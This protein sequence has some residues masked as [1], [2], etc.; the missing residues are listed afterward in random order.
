MSLSPGKVFQPVC[1]RAAALQLAMAVR[2]R[3]LSGRGFRRDFDQFQ[4]AQPPER[5][6]D[7]AG[8]AVKFT[9]PTVQAIGQDC[10]PMGGLSKIRQ[11]FHSH[12]KFAPASG[13]S[14]TLLDLT[15]EYVDYSFA[16]AGVKAGQLAGLG[17]L[18]AGM[19]GTHEP[20]GWVGGW[21]I[22]RLVDW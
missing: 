5:G 10:G 15:R 16:Q 6:R 11:L 9:V 7:A 18:L 2:Q 19:V 8:V 22:G 12:E 13:G 3:G 1:Q 4:N 21:E 17:V 20:G 14:L